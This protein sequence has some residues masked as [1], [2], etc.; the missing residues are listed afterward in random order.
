M[1]RREFLAASAKLVV[2]TAT[3]RS[4]IACDDSGSSSAA[5]PDMDQTPTPD[6]AGAD[7]GP[8]AAV[9][10]DRPTAEVFTPGLASGDP[11][12]DSVILWTRVTPRSGA[13]GPVAVRWELAATPDFASLVASG[14]LVTTVARDGVIHP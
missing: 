2:V 5:G 8:D 11:R 7:A 9:T 14:D 13:R 6:A 4:L 3:A 12:A 1:N 10:Y